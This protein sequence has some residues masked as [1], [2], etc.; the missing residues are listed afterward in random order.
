M[1]LKKMFLHTHHCKYPCRNPVS[2][3]LNLIPGS[4]KTDKQAS[5]LMQIGGRRSGVIWINGD[6]MGGGDVVYIFRPKPFVFYFQWEVYK[7]KRR[8][9]DCWSGEQWRSTG[10]HGRQLPP[11]PAPQR[12]PSSDKHHLWQQEGYWVHRDN[13][14]WSCPPWLHIVSNL[15]WPARWY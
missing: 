5:G 10:P 7:N 14:S 8:D 9:P 3:S 13:S 1:F 11:H 15:F 12:P 4:L 6:K 2:I